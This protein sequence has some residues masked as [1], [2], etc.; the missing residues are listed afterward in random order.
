M[1]R[2]NSTPSDCRQHASPDNAVNDAFRPGEREVPDLQV[3]REDRSG[4]PKGNRTPVT[5]VKGRCPNR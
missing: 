5:A 3:F 1:A 2:Q 4:T